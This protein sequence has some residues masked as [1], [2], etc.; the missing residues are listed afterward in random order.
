[1]VLTPPGATDAARAALRA[2]QAALLAALLDGAP[3]P[4][5]FD[6]VRVAVQARAL[7]ARRTAYGQPSEP[8][9]GGSRRAGRLRR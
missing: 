3:A 9:R 2:E 8:D 4:A 7:V 1:V 5:G 6:P